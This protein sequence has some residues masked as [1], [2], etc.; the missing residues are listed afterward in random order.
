MLVWIIEGEIEHESPLTTI[1]RHR[2]WCL[3]SVAG[4]IKGQRGIKPWD[5]LLALL[6]VWEVER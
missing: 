3:L 5:M 2:T 1:H 4:A 6:L